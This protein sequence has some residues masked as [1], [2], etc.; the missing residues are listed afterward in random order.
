VR[1]EAG[2]EFLNGQI[3]EKP[4]SIRSKIVETQIVCLLMDV[5]AQAKSTQVFTASM[6]YRCFIDDPSKVRKPDVSIVR[7]VRLHGHNENESFIRVRPDL[8]IEIVSRSDLAAELQD[9]IQDYL[10]N[11][12]PL[13]WVVYPSLKTVTIFRLDG[14]VA[15][16]HEKD[17]ITGESALP[18][19]RCKVAQ[20]F[21]EPAK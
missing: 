3:H 4:V 1:D 7:S 21:P 9:R 16:L 10:T 20:F 19:F 12:F 15:T 14:M 11:G 2:V 13:I 18:N 17:E 6:G 8:A 5:A